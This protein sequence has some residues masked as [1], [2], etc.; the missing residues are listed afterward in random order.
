MAVK[1]ILTQIMKNESHVIERMLNSIKSIVDGVCIVDT[2]STD[3]SVEV[4]KKWGLDN[5]I[6][7]YVHQMSFDGFDI[8]RNVSFTKAREFFLSKNDG[9]TYYNFWLD[10]DEQLVVDSKFDKTKINKDLYM[11]NTFI[12]AMK[13]TRNE[14]CRL[15]KPFRFYGPIHEFIV[16]D[17]A[18]I[19]SGLMEG[20]YV[21]VQMDGASWKGNVPSKYLSHAHKLETYIDR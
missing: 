8:C 18:N 2:G 3:N 19:S 9:H 16:C 6:E 14:L 17:E 10:A 11:F 21:N 12:G 15:D 20:L 13:Y 1:L 5:N 4:V 7:T